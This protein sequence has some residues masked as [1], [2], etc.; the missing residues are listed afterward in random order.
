[1]R[2][3]AR[4]FI[5]CQMWKEAAAALEEVILEERTRTGTG[6]NPREQRELQTLVL[7]AGRLYDQA[8]LLDEAAE[9]LEKG[10][11]HVAAAEVRM[12]KGDLEKAA[13]LFLLGNQPV[14]AASFAGV[15]TMTGPGSAIVVD[16]SLAG[17][18]FGSKLGEPSSHRLSSLTS[19][20]EVPNP[21]GATPGS[22]TMYCDPEKL[23]APVPY[24]LP[25]PPGAKIGV[26]V[27]S[28]QNTHCG[29]GSS[30]N[31]DGSTSASGLL[32][33]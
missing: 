23:S 11:C 28:G 24:M 1:M 7:Q 17:Q 10:G 31:P 9:V 22:P 18:A 25:K 4:A 27:G 8:G 5:R 2:Q 19:S 6:Q 13:E 26:N 30:V 32:R 15:A 14:R 33:T 12:R 3:A 20:S 16:A 29:G 21:C